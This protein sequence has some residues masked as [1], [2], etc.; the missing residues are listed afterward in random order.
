MAKYQDLS[1]NGNAN[2]MINLNSTHSWQH[3]ADVQ[4]S[5]LTLAAAKARL[6][7]G[8]QAAVGDRLHTLAAA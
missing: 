1:R 8:D 5:R 4:Q 7:D 6:N 2:D 3:T